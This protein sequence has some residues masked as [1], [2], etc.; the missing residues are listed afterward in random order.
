MTFAT[1]K[2]DI[3]SWLVD[4]TSTNKIPSFVAL[5][6]SAIRRDVRVP[7]MDAT[8]SAALVA[9]VISLPADFIEVKRL[10][11]DGY[12]YT[13]KPVEVFQ[14]METDG[15]VTSGS[16]GR[17]Y[18]RIGQTLRILNGGTSTYSLLYVAKFDALSSDS[19]SNWLLENASDVYLFKSLH[20]GAAWLK[21]KPAAEA[22]EAM[23]QAAVAALVMTER[24]SQFSGPLSMNVSGA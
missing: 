16:A 6:E 23:Y 20:Y 13:F 1:L 4:S 21:D 22:Y 9:G 2:T 8:A 5:A 18:T 15:Y 11:I 7:A 10:V 12:V 19:D 14:Q 24:M 3:A 17:F